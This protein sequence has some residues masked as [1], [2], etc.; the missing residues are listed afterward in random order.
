MTRRHTEAK[1]GTTAHPMGN[2]WDQVF[3]HAPV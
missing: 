1:Y 3:T 2:P